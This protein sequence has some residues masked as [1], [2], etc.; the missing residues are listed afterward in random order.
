MK[1]LAWTVLGM[2]PGHVAA[3]S[4]GHFYIL[5]AAIRLIDEG[6]ICVSSDIRWY[7]DTLLAVE[8]ACAAEAYKSSTKQTAQLKGHIGIF[9][10]WSAASWIQHSIASRGSSSLSKRLQA[11]D[12]L[13]HDIISFPIS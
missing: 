13:V 4:L 5:P 7:L 1:P 9:T 3:L 8:L 12:S 2:K 6:R 11:K 10:L